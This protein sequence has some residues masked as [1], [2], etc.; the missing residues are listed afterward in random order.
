MELRVIFTRQQL[1]VINA[2]D[3]HSMAKLWFATHP[4]ADEFAEGMITN[5]RMAGIM[6]AM[7]LDINGNQIKED[8]SAEIYLPDS[9]IL[10]IK[11]DLYPAFKFVKEEPMPL[12]GTCVTIRLIK[13]KT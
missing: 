10:D 6:E 12:F 5:M 8:V 3:I 13:P 11:E 2:S 4:R 9:L 7:I 1:D